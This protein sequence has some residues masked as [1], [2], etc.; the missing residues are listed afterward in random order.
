MTQ[1]HT[2]QQGYD[3]QDWT[4]RNSPCAVEMTTMAATLVGAIAV[5][6]KA[7]LHLGSGGAAVSLLTESL[8]CAR[9]HHSVR[10]SDGGAGISV[11]RTGGGALTVAVVL[12]GRHACVTFESMTV[13]GQ[14]N[15]KQQG[16]SSLHGSRAMG[17][18]VFKSPEKEWMS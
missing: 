12:I 7:T 2:Q 11:L 18:C 14:R 8:V 15:E 5:I 9:L 13:A 6:A 4:G 10:P 16:Q 1:G 3:H 17:F